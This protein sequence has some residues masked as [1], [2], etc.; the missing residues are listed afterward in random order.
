[1]VNV[2]ANESIGS[3]KRKDPLPELQSPKGGFFAPFGEPKPLP[4]GEV[5]PKVTERA[6]P[7][8]KSRCAAMGRLFVRAILSLCLGFAVSG[9]ALSVGL[10]PASSPKGGALGMSVSFRLDERSTMSRKQQC[11]AA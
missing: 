1:M 3:P 5:S 9:L 2:E 8:G 4:L 11:S 6:S 10:A 7:A